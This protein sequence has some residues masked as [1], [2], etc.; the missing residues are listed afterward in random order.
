[1]TCQQCQGIMIIK[2]NL[3][4]NMAASGGAV[5]VHMPAHV[6]GLAT[7]KAPTTSSADGVLMAALSRDSAALQPAFLLRLCNIT[8]NRAVGLADTHSGGQGQSGRGGGL[9]LVGSPRNALSI[10]GSDFSNNSAVQDGGAVAIEQCKGDSNCSVLLDS[11]VMR[12]NEAL[13]GSGGAVY[14]GDPSVLLYSSPASTMRGQVEATG[15]SSYVPVTAAGAT[16]AAGDLRSNRARSGS[17]LASDPQSL[18]YT[19][20]A[21]GSNLSYD[22]ALSAK[23]SNDAA[24]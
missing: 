18:A 22:I 21:A 7:A 8:A 9:L 4:G 10:T 3:A 5:A 6:Q 1:M 12:S 2:G 17:A 19:W 14:A 13:Q 15:N 11:T 16:K 20:T 24:H 23:V